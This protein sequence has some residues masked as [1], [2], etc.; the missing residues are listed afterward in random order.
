MILIVVP[1]SSSFFSAYNKDHDYASTQLLLSFVMGNKM[2]EK[3]TRHVEH[4]KILRVKEVYIVGQ[5][6]KLY[7][8]LKNTQVLS[9]DLNQTLSHQR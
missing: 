5:F 6:F 2:N 8:V 7:T 3:Y 9:F 1:Y 4:V